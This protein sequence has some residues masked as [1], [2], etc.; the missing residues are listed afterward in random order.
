MALQ[1]DIIDSK[2]WENLSNASRVAFIHLKR[3]VVKPNPGEISLSYGEMEKIMHR[4]TFA[5]AIRE[6]EEIGFIT[7]EQRGGLYRKKNFFRFSDQWRKYDQPS[8]TKISTVDSA[9]ISTVDSQMEI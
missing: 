3:K 6:L 1:W 2:A 4:H 5:G 9:K 8:S 7:R